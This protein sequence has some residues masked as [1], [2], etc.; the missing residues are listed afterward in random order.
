VYADLNCVLSI[1]VLLLLSL[2]IKP[3]LPL[4][5]A[6]PELSFFFDLINDQNCFGFSVCS[7]LM[8]S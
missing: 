2:Y 3:S 7:G 4:S 8:I 6:T 5:G 1:S